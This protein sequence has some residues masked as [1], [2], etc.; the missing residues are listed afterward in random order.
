[1][2]SNYIIKS[3][4]GLKVRKS[5]SGIYTVWAPN[6]QGIVT[7]KLTFKAEENGTVKFVRSN[8][9][10]RPIAI[11]SLV[12]Y[13]LMITFYFFDS[14]QYFPLEQVVTIF[15]GILGFFILLN[16]MLVHATK[17]KVRRQLKKVRN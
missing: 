15:L 3:T 17:S 5:A 12:T 4:A 6:H 1:M 11:N 9:Q 14:E 2:N 10:Y 7:P 8:R 16:S 13:A